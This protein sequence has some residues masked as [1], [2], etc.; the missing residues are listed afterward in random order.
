[1]I[2]PDDIIPSLAELLAMVDDVET[3]S[4][5]VTAAE[6]LRDTAENGR[7]SAENT[8]VSHESARVTA[9]KRTSYPQ[10]AEGLAQRTDVYPQRAEGLAQRTDVYPQKTAAYLLNRIVAARNRFENRIPL[11]R[12][13][14]A[15]KQ[16]MTQ[17]MLL[18][19]R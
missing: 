3:L 16:P 10:R 18:P 19:L 13:P 4:D 7:V 1:M 9:E 12:S 11:R 8:R 15:T 14:T 6:A 17:T 5:S 2:D